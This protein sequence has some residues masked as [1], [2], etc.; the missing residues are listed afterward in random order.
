M[1]DLDVGEPGDGGRLEQSGV[2]QPGAVE[3]QQVYFTLPQGGQAAA[4]DSGVAI[5]QQIAQLG[6]SG[7]DGKTG[8]GERTVLHSEVG[9]AFMPCKGDKQF[10]GHRIAF[11][12]EAH[13]GVT[14]Q[15]LHDLC[16]H[17]RDFKL[18]FSV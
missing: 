11:H 18:L 2:V 9:H 16:G 1:V 5:Q 17:F 13:Q 7:K 10:I 14:S 15:P 3:R 8:I 4:V 12:M 6:H